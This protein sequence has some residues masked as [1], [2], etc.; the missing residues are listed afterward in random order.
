M[1]LYAALGILG[2]WLLLRFLVPWLLPFII[3]FVLARLIE[4]IVRLLSKQMKLPRGLASAI[5]VVIVA[6]LL[7]T[8]FTLAIGRIVYELA[9]LAGD[10]PALLGDLTQVFSALR[11]KLNAYILA[12]PAEL[13]GYLIDALDGLSARSADL[14]TSLSGGILGFLS[15]AA[16]AG[17][18][19]IV[20]IFTCAIS[21]FFISSGWT[22][23]T[24]FIMRQIP[25][26]HHHALR[27]FRSD[28][29]STLGR[30]LKAQLMLSG[31]TF[32]ELCVAFVVLRIDFA[33]LLA[34]VVALFDALPVF[35]AGAVLLPWALIS[36]LGGELTRAV[37]L[38]VSF[39]I[40]LLVR[41]V[42]EPKLVG[43]Q[44]GLAP[45]AT[46]VAMYI[47]LC[48]FG[49]AGMVLFPIG[50]IMLKHLNDRGYVQLWTN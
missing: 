34:L 11:D 45:I 7:I 39:G 25:K 44:I 19:V 10:I 14:L 36:L 1:L 26:R 49:I 29:R 8:L 41:N 47:G 4:P 30:W 32:L 50:L 43:A 37:T 18:R 22:A 35:G 13:R 15:S 16:T 5:C 31:V 3:A 20:F 17:P 24:G 40:I 46:L 42:L 2:V 38:A 12:A 48:S 6:A 33:I 28:L 23:T 9:A 21:T 27:D